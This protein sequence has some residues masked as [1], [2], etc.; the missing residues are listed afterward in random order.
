MAII[1]ADFTGV[2][3]GAGFLEPGTYR[4]EVENVAQ[5]EGRNYPGL[6]WTW[7]SVEDASYGQQ[8]DQFTSLSPKALWVLKGILEAL[9]AEIP[10]SVVRLD[11]DRLIGRTAFIHVVNEPWVGS[12]GE[13]HPSSRVDRVLSVPGAVP[14]NGESQAEFKVK[15]PASLAT[16]K[17]AP[18]GDFKDVDFGDEAHIPF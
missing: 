8:A 16:A 12:D 2:T 10:Q 18:L 4:A 17:A 9:G 14:G 13:E 11:T 15:A 3:S 1:E 6:K 5:V 7:R